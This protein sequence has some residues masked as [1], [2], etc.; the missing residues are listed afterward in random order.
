MR[1]LSLFILNILITSLAFADPPEVTPKPSLTSLQALTAATDDCHCLRE[2]G[3]IHKDN[4]PLSPGQTDVVSNV[5]SV[6]AEALKDLKLKKTESDST[7]D[8]FD[9]IHDAI[10][11]KSIKSADGS[12]QAGP[13]LKNLRSRGIE[14][15]I[16]KVF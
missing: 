10:N 7:R 16:K 12:L 5:N 15:N 3:A 9:T 6:V 13:K 1:I 14:L 11:A 4:N 8:T 2:F